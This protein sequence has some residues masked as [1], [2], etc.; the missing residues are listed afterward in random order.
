MD[1]MIQVEKKQCSFFKWLEGNQWIV[2]FT[3]KLNAI[4][5]LVVSPPEWLP[6]P[7]PLAIQGISLKVA[8]D[9]LFSYS[10]F[11]GY[12]VNPVVTGHDTLDWI[13]LF[14]HELH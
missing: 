11:K 14:P 7:E 1:A 13:S 5:F 6:Y 3:S 10:D 12:A 4:H 8:G 9:V 2:A